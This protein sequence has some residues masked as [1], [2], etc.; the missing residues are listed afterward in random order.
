MLSVVS[1]DSDKIVLSVVATTSNT[2]Y[3]FKLTY[4]INTKNF[5]AKADYV[6]DQ[7]TRVIECSSLTKV[8]E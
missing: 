5:S 6:Y 3:T 4:N 8:T 7:E 1:Q 2:T